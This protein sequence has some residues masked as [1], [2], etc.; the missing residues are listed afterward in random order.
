[1]N[2]ALAQAIEQ[3]VAWK[4]GEIHA[5][6]VAFVK[7]GLAELAAGRSYFGP[8][9]LPAALTFNGQGIVG[10]VVHMLRESHVIEDCVISRPEAGIN[11]GR[12]RSLRPSANGRKI[13]L[14][15]LCSETAARAWLKANGVAV[16]EVQGEL[17]GG[18]N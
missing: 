3:Q 7:A 12:R 18:L 17:F 5:A 13:S 8:D 1:M 16:A 11:H 15:S 6:A 2:E 10:S 4:P 14:Y 9:N